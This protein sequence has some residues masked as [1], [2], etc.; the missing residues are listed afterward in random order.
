MGNHHHD[1]MR[2]IIENNKRS[3]EENVMTRMDLLRQ[4]D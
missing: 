2:N 1:D 4:N 3:I